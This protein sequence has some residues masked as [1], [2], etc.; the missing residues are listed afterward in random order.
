MK[1]FTIESDF[2]CEV[3]KGEQFDLIIG[4]NATTGYGWYLKEVDQKLKAL[5]LNEYK[6]ADYV[7]DPHPEGFV[8]VPGKYHF[9]FEALEAGE[10]VLEFTY[11]R[12]W[13]NDSFKKNIV[14]I[15]IK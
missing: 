2:V 6:S 3:E 15:L 13:E 5:N 11:Q 10:A 8:G 12:P 14:K 9:K 4:G 7:T 1:E